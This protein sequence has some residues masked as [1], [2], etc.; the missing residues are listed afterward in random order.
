MPGEFRL[1]QNYPNPFN[2]TTKI[3]FSIPFNTEVNLSVYNTLGERVTILKSGFYK[4][5]EYEAE[6]NAENLPSG[7]YF[8]RLQAGNF[9]QTRKLVLVR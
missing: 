9:Q 1:E 5:G 7:I 3:G 2:P 8:Y 4:A 6:F